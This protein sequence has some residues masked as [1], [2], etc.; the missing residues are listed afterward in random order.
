VCVWAYK[1]VVVNQEKK[2]MV[3][4]CVFLFSRKRESVCVCI[5]VF[6]YLLTTTTYVDYV[7][8]GAKRE[9]ELLRVVVCVC[10]LR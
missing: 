7:F 2:P 10:V 6:L 8:Y 4:V 3:S 9:W 1:I 5:S